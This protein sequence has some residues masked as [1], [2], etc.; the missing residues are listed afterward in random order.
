MARFGLPGATV[1]YF[2]PMLRPKVKF[3]RAVL[4]GLM[5]IVGSVRADVSYYCD[6]MNAVMHDDCCSMGADVDQMMVNDGEP[7]CE[8]SVD[9]VIDTAAD[10]VPTTPKPIKF[11]SDVDPPDA[12]VS[13]FS[14][15][16]LRPDKTAVSG[17]GAEAT[18][19]VNG[20]SIYLTTQRLR[21]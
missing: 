12:S 1:V 20:S 16:S 13:I 7:C 17:V 14:L 21:I 2:E 5:L 11:E 3:V 18:I 8:T 6:M 15:A 10:Q 19:R 9:L 4:V